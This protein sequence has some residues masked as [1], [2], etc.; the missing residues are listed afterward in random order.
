[1][2]VD[3][4]LTETVIQSIIRVH[5]QLGPG[6][7]ESIYKNALIIELAKRSVSFETEKDVVVYYDGHVVGKHRIDVFVEGQL[8]LEL[9]TVDQLAGVHYAQARSYLKATGGELALLVNFAGEKADFR[10]VEMK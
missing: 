4:H 7:Q 2:S 10:R 1:M 3:G 8:I 9:K 5:Q 6:F